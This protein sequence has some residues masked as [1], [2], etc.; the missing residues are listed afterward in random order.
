MFLAVLSAGAS[1]AVNLSVRTAIMEG[2]LSATTTSVSQRGIAVL[3]HFPEYLVRAEQLGARH[4]NIPANVWATMSPLQR[5][6]ANEKFLSEIVA[7][8]DHIVL[9][10]PVGRVTVGSTLEREIRYLLGRGY[11]IVDD[12]WRLVPGK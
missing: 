6:S 7:R 2:S 8:G 3:G 9:T 11:Q 1:Q 12:G 10:T 4:F 5:W